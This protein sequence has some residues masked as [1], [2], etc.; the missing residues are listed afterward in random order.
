MSLSSAHLIALAAAPAAIL[1]SGR[2]LAPGSRP[3][4]FLTVPATWLIATAALCWLL[5]D[6]SDISASLL[7][8]FVVVPCIGIPVAAIV[9]TRLV[10]TR[11][12]LVSAL[13]LSLLGWICGL[14]V[15][16]LVG[17][18]STAGLPYYFWVYAVGLALPATYAACGAV[19]AAGLGDRTA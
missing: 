16:L 6:P 7:F 9:A 13:L 3:A 19:V 11:G 10:R 14:G 4:L 2:R 17:A 5:P 8:F 15:G 1:L 18:N 12:R